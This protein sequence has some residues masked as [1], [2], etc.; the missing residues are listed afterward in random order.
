MEYAIYPHPYFRI[1]Q[2]PYGNVSH[3]DISQSSASSSINDNLL[4]KAIDMG[5]QYTAGSQREK[6]YAPFTCKVL[7]KSSSYGTVYFGSC[8]ANGT[9]KAIK[10]SDG[11][12]SSVTCAMTHCSD[13]SWLEVGMIFNAGDHIYNEGVS[14]TTDEHVHVEFARGW[15]TSKETV[16]LDVKVDGVNVTYGKATNRFPLS[17]SLYPDQVLQKLANHTDSS[18]DKSIYSTS[19]AYNTK[20][21]QVAKLAE[22]NIS[23]ITLKAKT[24]VLIRSYPGSTKT[25]KTLTSGQTAEIKRF[26]GVSS[27][28]NYQWVMVK[29]NDGVYGY[30]QLD[31]KGYS[32]VNPN[33]F[34]P[35]KT[36]Y[37]YQDRNAAYNGFQIRLN[38]PVDGQ[39]WVVCPKGR[40]AEIIAFTDVMS[41]GYQ[42]VQVRYT[43]TDGVTKVGFVQFDTYMHN[44]VDINR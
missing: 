33:S 7:A 44:M 26:L 11:T 19:S 13:I 42:W 43:H 39:K 17:V 21:K 31:P 16:H 34:N 1:T 28:D 24:N 4:V 22:D 8:D 3:C 6:F 25:L 23:G 41:D 2:S 29:T 20:F 5:G 9:E 38:Y 40:K 15:V 35:N 30:A 37:L 10:L 27:K 36:L 18:E 14:G 32:I 12:T